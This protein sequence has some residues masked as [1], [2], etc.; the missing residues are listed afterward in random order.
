MIAAVKKTNLGEAG[1]GQSSG[2]SEDGGNFNKG[3]P[4]IFSN[5]YRDGGSLM[6]LENFPTFFPRGFN[7]E[8]QVAATGGRNSC[9]PVGSGRP[10][11]R[12]TTMPGV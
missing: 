5:P 3:A 4:F 11:G 2:S 1:S 7:S 8:A 12:N 10:G 9:G 6:G